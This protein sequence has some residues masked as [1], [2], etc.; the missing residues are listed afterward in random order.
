M[1]V[2]FNHTTNIKDIIKFYPIILYTNLTFEFLLN[3]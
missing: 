1:S 2:L 3:L